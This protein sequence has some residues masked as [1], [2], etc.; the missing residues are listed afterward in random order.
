MV[1]SFLKLGNG[2]IN[3]L[4]L[5]KMLYVA[6]RTMLLQSGN[7]IS[8]DGWCSMKYGPVL[9]TTLNLMRGKAEGGIW[10]KHLKTE[11]YDLL[12]ID[13]PGDD[14]LSVAEDKVIASTYAEW[15]HLAPFEAARR[16]HDP[17]EF[18]EY[19]EIENGSIPIGIHEVLR[20][21]GMNGDE[22]AHV[23]RDLEYHEKFAMLV[24]AE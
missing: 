2:K 21:H 1:A 23:L 7:T 11:D 4:L 17:K 16:T 9:S 6:D 24:G 10:S 15:G 19:T 3:Y 18:P 12:L 14:E 22:I 13:D 5:M 20:L 8:H